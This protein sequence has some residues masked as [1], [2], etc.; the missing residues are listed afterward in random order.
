MCTNVGVA[1]VFFCVTFL[2]F[3]M[4]SFNRLELPVY[5]SYEQLKDKLMLAM[6]NA[7]GFTEE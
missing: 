6:D 7:E 3:D 5:P 1:Y 2:F 4:P